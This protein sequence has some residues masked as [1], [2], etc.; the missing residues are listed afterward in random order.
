MKI[1]NR[2]SVEVIRY[3]NTDY[4]RIAHIDDDIIEWHYADGIWRD[5]SVSVKHT[6]ELE[7]AYQN[8]IKGAE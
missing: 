6:K 8:L 4:E 3:E 5:T 2:L 7:T 1:T